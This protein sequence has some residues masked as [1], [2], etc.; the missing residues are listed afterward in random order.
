MLV[1]DYIKINYI[2][3]GY[4]PNHS[5]F[6]IS[7]EEMIDAFR[8]EDGFFNEYYPCPDESSPDMVE[9]YE[10]LRT[11]IWGKLDAYL[12][13]PENVKIPNW[14]YSYM[15]LNAVT[16]GSEEFGG[17]DEADIAYLYEL[18]GIKSPNPLAEFTPQLAWG[19]Y[20]TSQEWM[21]KNPSRYRDRPPTMFGEPHV[22]K[23]LRVKQANILIEDEE[24]EA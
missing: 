11:C 7:D 9:A 16:F 12:E 24:E 6:L 18:L 5:Y 22:I 1:N 15:I 8:K 4:L 2:E 23:C 10:A 20:R 19:C 13:D 17:S 14:V 3:L 21:K